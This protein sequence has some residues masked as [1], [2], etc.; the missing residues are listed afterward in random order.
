MNDSTRFPKIW[1]TT[2]Q[3]VEENIQRMAERKA[4]DAPGQSQQALWRLVA[5]CE[6]NIEIQTEKIKSKQ[7]ETERKGKLQEE[8]M[9]KGKKRKVEFK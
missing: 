4:K 8:K 7:K 6:G 3:R 1:L 5:E 2:T 9:R